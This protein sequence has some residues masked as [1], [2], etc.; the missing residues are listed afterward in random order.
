MGNQ[1][2]LQVEYSDQAPYPEGQA[3]KLM[4]EEALLLAEYRD[5]A[6]YLVRQALKLMAEEAPLLVEYSDL[7]PLLVTLQELLPTHRE[8]ILWIEIHQDSLW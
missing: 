5:P 1:A 4:A 3:F 6:A 8:G 7:D 2:P